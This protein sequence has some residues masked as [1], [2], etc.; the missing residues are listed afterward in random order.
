M[1]MRD[2]IDNFKKIGSKL[3]KMQREYLFETPDKVLDRMKQKGFKG[4][5]LQTSLTVDVEDE[6]LKILEG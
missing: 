2:F 5:I 3:A 1:A 6:L 4:K